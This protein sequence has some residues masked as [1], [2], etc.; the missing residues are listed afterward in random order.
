MPDHMP[1]V[2]FA[3]HLRL[4]RDATLPLFPPLKACLHAEQSLRRSS[5]CSLAQ[6]DAM[7]TGTATTNR[8]R[9][10][11][12]LQP[13]NQFH[14]SGLPVDSDTTSRSLSNELE[15]ATAPGW[16]AMSEVNP[17]HLRS[18]DYYVNFMNNFLNNATNC[19]Q[20]NGASHYTPTAGGWSS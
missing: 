17:R 13:Y 10:L 1:P 15:L 7:A 18:L 5:K 16:Q 2:I 14:D 4:R 19:F 12:N 3:E 11:F 9:Q 8:F 20:Q 6:S